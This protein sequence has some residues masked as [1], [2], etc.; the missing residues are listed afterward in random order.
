MENQGNPH[1]FSS[2]VREAVRR[3]FDDEG[4]QSCGGANKQRVLDLA[5]EIGKT[6]QQTMVIHINASVQ[7]AQG[8]MNVYVTVETRW[9]ESFHC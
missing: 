6:P 7:S 5:Q 2:D 9:I 1:P 3:A 4:L 8:G